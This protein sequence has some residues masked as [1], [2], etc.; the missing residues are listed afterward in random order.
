MMSESSKEYTDS[1]PV[2]LNDL[3]IRSFSYLS[4]KDLFALGQVSRDFL[5]ISST[6]DLWKPICNRRWKGKQ[7][8]KRFMRKE[9]EEG[10]NDGRVT[11]CTDF[12]KQ[13]YSGSSELP[14]QCV[15]HVPKFSTI[16]ALIEGFFIELPAINMGSLMHTPTSWKESYIMAEIDSKRTKISKEELVHFKWKLIYDGRPSVN[17]LRQFNA[18]GTYHSP[19][20][21]LTN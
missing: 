3:W 5:I 12:I 9:G 17:G 6:D 21:G 8:I 10:I 20:M 14:A 11:Y 4:E 2:L 19:Y 18:D 7:N 15:R 13:L 1:S 16:E